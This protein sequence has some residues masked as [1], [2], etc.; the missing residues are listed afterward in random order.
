MQTKFG[1]VNLLSSVLLKQMGAGYYLW[2]LS[3]A[4]GADPLKMSTRPA[5]FHTQK[6]HPPIFGLTHD[7]FAC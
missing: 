6:H 1:D 7:T 3:A 5:A 4:N 2:H